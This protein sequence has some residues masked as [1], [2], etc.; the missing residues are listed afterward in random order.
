VFAD[1]LCHPGVTEQVE[2][3]S[4]V[5]FLALHGGLEPGTSELAAEAA[6][7]SGASLYAVCQPDD[8]KWHVPAH[9]VD[10]GCVPLLARFLQHVDVVLSVHGYWRDDLARALLL[11]G[12]NRPLA[13]DLAGI[14]RRALPDYEVVDDLERIPAGLRGVNPLNPVNMT[15]GGGVQLELPHRVRAIGPFGH[16]YASQ[17]YRPHTER[18]VG[19][20]AQFAG[21]AA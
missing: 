3:R 9:Q 4:R 20:L 17:V 14:V 7:R 6:R 1:L 13:S 15:R 8:L 19:A 16:G 21:D 2:L 11:G 12:A 5:G 18:L 10:P